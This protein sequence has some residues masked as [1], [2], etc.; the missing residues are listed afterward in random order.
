[1]NQAQRFSPD[2]CFA[3]KKEIRMNGKPCCRV[4]HTWLSRYVQAGL[5]PSGSS[6]WSH[7]IFGELSSR[8]RNVWIIFC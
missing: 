6:R 7:S 8:K 1:M 2:D 5:D 3:D 4:P